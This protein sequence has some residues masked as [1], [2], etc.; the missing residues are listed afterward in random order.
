[1]GDGDM[2]LADVIKSALGGKESVSS[3]LDMAKL[4]GIDIPLS[5]D[6]LN[7]FNDLVSSGVFKDKSDFMKFAATAYM[8]N[9]VGSM[10]TEDK[11]PPE[12]AIM[13]IINKAGIGKSYPQGDIKKMLVPLLITAFFAIYKFMSKKPAMKTA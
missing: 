12:S 8:K 5:G 10:M 9:N 13:D 7:M 6:Q 2:G 4:A 3:M 11:A 1:M